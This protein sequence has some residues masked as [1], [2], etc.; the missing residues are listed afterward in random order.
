MKEID[1]LEIL[2]FN[3]HTTCLVFEYSL[4]PILCKLYQ[5]GILVVFVIKSSDVNIRADFVGSFSACYQ[6]R[7]RGRYS[8]LR[9]GATLTFK[10]TAGF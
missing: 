1:S 2:S 7:P 6:V 3:I 9:F 5:A 10:L 4:I 8:N